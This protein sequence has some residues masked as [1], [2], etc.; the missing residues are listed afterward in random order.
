MCGGEL[1]EMLAKKE[2]NCDFIVLPVMGNKQPKVSVYI[3]ATQNGWNS[4]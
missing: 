2:L 1:R 3:A 4:L